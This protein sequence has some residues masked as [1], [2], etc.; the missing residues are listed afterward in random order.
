MKYLLLLRTDGKNIPTPGSDAFNT[1][2]MAYGKFNNES[3]EAGVLLSG[4]PL[5]PADT[6]TTL[7]KEGNDIK[8]HDG[9]FAEL[10]EQINGWYLLDCK[11]LDSALKWA[12][13]VPM[14][15]FGYGSV[16]VRPC[17]EI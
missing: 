6:A 5:Q 14:V 9:P 13:K 7:R 17:M 8:L 10:K 1:Y 4:L 15:A 11:D 2:M 16:E 12:E 3:G